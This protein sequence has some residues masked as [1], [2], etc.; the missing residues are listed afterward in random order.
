VFLKSWCKTNILGKR[1]IA[2][3][4]A[5]NFKYYFYIDSDSLILSYLSVL[6]T[7]VKNFVLE[8]KVGKI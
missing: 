1:N 4:M 6:K 3:K 2:K 7:R 8:Q 5:K